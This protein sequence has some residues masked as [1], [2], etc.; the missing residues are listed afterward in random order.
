MKL[1]LILLVLSVF[2]AVEANK[3][4]EQETCGVK[5]P[6]LVGKWLKSWQQKHKIDNSVAIIDTGV[7]DF[8]S[9]KVARQIP[10]D[11]SVFFPNKDN[12][13]EAFGKAAFIIVFVDVYKTVSLN[14]N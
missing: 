1:K 2:C 12:S 4:F 10:N 5:V 3:M 6:N 11:Y 13:G 8:M 9:K 14:L 7:D